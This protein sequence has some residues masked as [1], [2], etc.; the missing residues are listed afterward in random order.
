VPP[1]AGWKPATERNE[2]V[3]SVGAQLTHELIAEAFFQQYSGVTTTDDT[4]FAFQAVCGM[5]LST[6]FHPQ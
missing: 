1:L 5:G 4:Y 3:S 2:L 6:W